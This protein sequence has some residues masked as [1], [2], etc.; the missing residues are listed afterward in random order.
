MP[1]NVLAVSILGSSFTIQSEKEPGHLAE[2]AEYLKN[3]VEEVRK[4]TTDCDN[5][6]V[7]L[8]A[9]LNIVDELFKAKR[10]G[11]TERAED[12][13]EIEKLTEKLIDKIDEGLMEN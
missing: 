1:K 10:A 3:K 13:L 12:S 11:E 7:S 9:A 2:I 4:N 6:T 8:L 5:L